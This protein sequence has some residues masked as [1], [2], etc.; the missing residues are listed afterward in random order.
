MRKIIELIHTSLSKG[1][2]VALCSI[3]KTTGSTARKAGAKMVVFGD[4]SFA[5]TI[6]GG[7]VEARG[8]EMADDCIKNNCSHIKEFDLSGKSDDVSD[9]ICGGKQSIL[10]ESVV[11]SDDTVALFKTALDNLDS[12]T[13][14]LMITIMESQGDRVIV[15]RG[16]Q[17]QKGGPV[18]YTEGFRE[19]AGEFSF[20]RALTALRPIF[21]E[22]GNLKCFAERL[23]SRGELIVAGAG[24]ISYF[25][26]RLGAMVDF[27]VHVIDDR[28]ELLSRERFPGAEGLK[29]V[30]QSYENSLDGFK[31]D[32]S[33]FIVICSRGHSADR[34]ILAQALKT[35]AGYIGMIGSARKRS[36]IY[37]SLLES[38]YREADLNRVHCPIGIPI[39]DE[40]PEEISV[41]I[42]AQLIKRRSEMGL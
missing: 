10:I 26:A 40:T 20:E 22:Q 34:E 7:L 4:G 33:T 30:D 6:G 36:A 11:P 17:D 28:A 8:L 15:H 14:A 42:V 27:A 25:L 31:I 35:S 16:L 9:M 5:G 21:M 18:A 37:A 39:G 32:S 38:G 1:E 29:H 13:P 19:L 24:H 3:V 23:L 2:P 12:K 41:G